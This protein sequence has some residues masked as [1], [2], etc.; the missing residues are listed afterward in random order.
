MVPVVTPLTSH[1]LKQQL[2]FLMR[3]NYHSLGLQLKAD[4]P[5]NIL[6]L[7]M[8]MMTMVATVAGL[9]DRAAE[10]PFHPR[11]DGLTE[12]ANRTI[13]QMLRTTTSQHLRLH[14]R[15]LVAYPLCRSG[16]LYPSALCVRF[17]CSTGLVLSLQISRDLLLSRLQGVR[18]MCSLRPLRLLRRCLPR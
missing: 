5:L 14:H 2:K 13:L 11:S 15:L 12:R 7:L 8:L 4:G 17:L 1:S 9:Y 18:A 6:G 16:V 10:K 3:C